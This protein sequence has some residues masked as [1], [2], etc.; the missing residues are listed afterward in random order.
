MKRLFG[1]N[2]IR[3]VVGTDMTVDLALG[4]GKA[5]G[6]HF[7]SGPIAI[8]RDTRTSGPMLRD[9]LVAGLLATGH[10]VV[11]AGVLPSPALQYFVRTG[12]FVGGVIVTASHNPAEFN[13]IKV[14]DSQGMELSR[15]EEEAIESRYF[16]G[17]FTLADWQT[18]GHVTVDETAVERYVTGILSHVDVGAIRARRF[19]VVLDSGN[20][21]ACMTSPLLLARLGA[22][23][24]SLNGHPDGRFPGRP[25][26]PV[27]EN[28]SALMRQ[29]RESKAHFGVAHDGDAD[30]AIFVDDRGEFVFG[31]RSLALIARD[32]VSRGGGVVVTPV[33]SSQCLEDVVRAAGG[34][35]RFTKVGA[36][37]VARA[38]YELGATFGG[39]ENGGIIFPEHQFCRDGAMA[40]AKMLEVL[41]RANRPLSALLSEL[42]SYSLHKTSVHFPPEERDAILARLRTLA[43]GRRI[44][45]TDGVKVYAD[46]GWF[47]VRPSGTEAIFRIFAESKTE[48]RA[49]ALAAEGGSLLRAAMARD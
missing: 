21:A 43:A 35:V 27:R 18:T 2:G 26:E 8:G 47:L 39:E 38:M 24:V 6:S 46:D 7:G 32:V 14:V 33:S 48:E 29:V 3:G 19:R 41:A 20:G 12:Q 15:P 4:V 17:T 5:I 28:L 30:R 10:D 13:G 22:E 9:A 16:E 44:D 34:T 40:L 11:D 45:D 49:K 25:P 23:V 31:D 1:T 37:I 42:P 36:P